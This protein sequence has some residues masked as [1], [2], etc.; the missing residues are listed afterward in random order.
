MTSFDAARL[1]VGD[2]APQLDHEVVGE[3]ESLQIGAVDSLGEVHRVLLVFAQLPD[4]GRWNDMPYQQ[5]PGETG[6]E[7]PGRRQGD[8]HFS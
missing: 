7:S 8:A 1:H 2:G 4:L 3:A 5:W 6:W